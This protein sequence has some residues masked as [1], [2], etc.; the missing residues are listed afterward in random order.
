MNAVVL[1]APHLLDEHTAK[2]S[3]ECG[4]VRSMGPEGVMP[5]NKTGLVFAERTD[6]HRASHLLERCL[7]V[8]VFFVLV[9]PTAYIIRLLRKRKKTCALVVAH[10]FF[11]CVT[12]RFTCYS[13]IIKS[14]YSMPAAAA[15]MDARSGGWW[16]AA[17]EGAKT[18]ARYLGYC[19]PTASLYGWVLMIITREDTR[20]LRWGNPAK[21]CPI[22]YVRL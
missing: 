16:R 19:S 14:D 5:V 4:L 6:G 9:L 20:Q 1:T 15:G 18:Q 7:F 22:V 12:I 11:L 21:P 8:K 17:P 2:L 3:F 10:V 13:R